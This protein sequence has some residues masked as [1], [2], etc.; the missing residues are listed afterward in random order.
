MVRILRKV[1]NILSGWFLVLIFWDSEQAKKRRAI[2]KACPSRKGIVCGICLCPLPM[3]TR[4][5][6]EY[7]DLGKWD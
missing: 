2:C 5:K 3:K 6:D 4:V 7:C 1:R